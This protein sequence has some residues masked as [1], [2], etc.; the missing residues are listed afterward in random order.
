[1]VINMFLVSEQWD[2]LL[3]DVSIIKHTLNNINNKLDNMAK[4]QLVAKDKGHSDKII[5]HLERI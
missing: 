2:K 4:D 1:M 3:Q 5:L